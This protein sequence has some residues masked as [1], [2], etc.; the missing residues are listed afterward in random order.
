MIR[1]VWGHSVAMT[2]HKECVVVQ[3]GVTH[4]AY[5]TSNGKA[6]TPILM[7]FVMVGLAGIA[8]S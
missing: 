4:L 1:I 8:M 6:R 7:R 3:L 5:L 2:H